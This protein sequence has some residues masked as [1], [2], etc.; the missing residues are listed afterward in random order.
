MLHAVTPPIVTGAGEQGRSREAAG[1]KA[2]F[3]KPSRDLTPFS[4][5]ALLLLCDLSDVFWSMRRS[6]GDA[7]EGG[8]E[9]TDSIG[10]SRD[11]Q[12]L[13]P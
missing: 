5:P 3:K 9:V 11:P 1:R 4:S 10:T 6:V 2:R 12:R 13:I 7:V 8:A